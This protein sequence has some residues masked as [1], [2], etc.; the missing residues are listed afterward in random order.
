MSVLSSWASG[1]SRGFT[2]ELESAL[3]VLQTHVNTARP[4]R[5]SLSSMR[6]FYL[7]TDGSYEPGS[8]APACIGGILYD[9]EGKALRFFSKRAQA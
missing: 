1:H 9:S 8:S 4:L 3:R 7:F 2:A 5:I 6:T